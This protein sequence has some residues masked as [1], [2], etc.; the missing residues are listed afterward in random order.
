[1]T[2]TN[3]LTDRSNKRTKIRSKLKLTT[4]PGVQ[5]MIDF[6]FVDYFKIMCM[7]AESL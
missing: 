1:M 2:Q 7:S 4:F 6:C 5:E 3:G